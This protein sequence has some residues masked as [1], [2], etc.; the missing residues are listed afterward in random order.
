MEPKRGLRWWPAGLILGLAAVIVIW[1]RTQGEWSFQERNI[2]TLST[3]MGVVLLLFV[4]WLALSRAPWRLRVAVAGMVIGMIAVTTALFR[5]QGVSGDLRPILNTRWS[6]RRTSQSA[7]P[8]RDNAT[9][10][11]IIH[12]G[13]FPQ[14]LGPDRNAQLARPILKLDWIATPPTIVWRH[15]IGAGWSG[16]AI[17]SARAFTQEQEGENEC[18]TC[19]DLHTGQRLWTHAEPVHYANALAGEGPRC[20]PT[21]ASNR[22]VTLG[23]T[24]V[25]DCLDLATGNQL[26][27]RNIVD[28]AHSKV[29]EWGFAGSPLVYDG[30]VIVSAGGAAERSL[31]AYDLTSGGLLWHA[32]NRRTS[33][34]SPFLATLSGVRQ[35][36]AFNS[37]Y[38]TSHDAGSGHVLWEYQWGR[39]EPQVAVP[40]VVASNQVLFSSGYGIGSELLE[41]QS[42][43]EGRLSATQVW[44]SL[45][46]KAKFASLVQ[47]EGFLYGLDDGVLACLD[48]KDGSQRWKE[49]RYGHG[50]GLLVGD[51]FL[52]MAENG[53]LVLLQ[54]SP[55]APK[56]LH[57]FRVFN[58]KTWNPIALSG[59]LLL[60]RNDQEAA[61]VRLPIE[62]SSAQ[63]SGAP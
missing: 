7:N 36:L 52:L 29:P 37:R 17:V 25:L 14:F 8:S 48:L 34:G 43:P 2:G 24:G 41:I 31:L 45:K 56:E 6:S 4:W 54:L 26:W 18:S 9:R 42:G 60:A 39:G 62:P 32:G 35:V 46:M 53:E 55:Q 28:D 50:Q 33:Y 19:Y 40:V 44:R 38:I 23:A 20:T 21:V 15:A 61:C 27:S 47:R 51:V 58:A 13:D 5:F 22:V 57:R 10:A 3:V 63:P 49:G 16:W 30:K 11:Q 12:G 59:E 1:I